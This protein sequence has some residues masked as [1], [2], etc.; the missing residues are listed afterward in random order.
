MRWVVREKFG[1]SG[2][3]REV[4]GEDEAALLY[5]D[6]SSRPL[7]KLEG[8]R[9]TATACTRYSRGGADGGK[10]VVRATARRCG[11]LEFSQVSSLGARGGGQPLRKRRLPDVFTTTPAF[12]LPLFL[13]L[14]WSGSLKSKELALEREP[15]HPL[16]F[17]SQIISFPTP[18][19]AQTPTRPTL[20][21]KSSRCHVYIYDETVFL[22]SEGHFIL[23][24]ACLVILILYL[25]LESRYP[26]RTDMASVSG[27]PAKRNLLL[28]FDAFGT[29]FVPRKPIAVQYAK[30]ASTHLGRKFSPEELS[31]LEKS[32]K[33]S[34]RPFSSCSASLS[35]FVIINKF[36]TLLLPSSPSSILHEYCHTFSLR[37]ITVL[38]ILHFAAFHEQSSLYPNYGKAVSTLPHFGDGIKYLTDTL[39]GWN[40]DFRLVGSCEFFHR[41]HCCLA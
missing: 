37:D 28:C 5:S 29:L 3:Y 8:L 17:N 21:A 25:S 1:R 39:L 7:Q 16:R 36:S 6:S 40:E 12:R 27:R 22:T 15:F 31:D 2:G 13:L 35:Y 23:F 38:L 24:L 18:H 11:L 30:V 33:Y 34:M 41:R 32:F 14:D 26:L 4:C 20:T 9:G 10:G 19:R